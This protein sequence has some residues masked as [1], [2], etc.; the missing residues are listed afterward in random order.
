MKRGITIQLEEDTYDYVK[1]QA[2]FESLS[3]SSWV[4]KLLVDKKRSEEVSSE[5]KDNG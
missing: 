2:E 3:M 4:R 1:Q 5:T